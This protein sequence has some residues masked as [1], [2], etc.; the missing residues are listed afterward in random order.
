MAARVKAHV[1]PALITWARETAG[2]STPAE[3]AARLKIE[4]AQLA[5]WEDPTKEQKPSIPQ[6]RKLAA[7]FRRPLAVFYMAEPPRTFAVMRDLRRLPGTGP[8]HYSPALQL[9]I[10]TANERRELALELATDLERGIQRFTLAATQRE[11]PER[12]GDRIRAT[13]DVTA[14]LQA[15]WRDT[16]GRIVHPRQSFERKIKSRHPRAQP[17]HQSQFN[18]APCNTKN[19]PC[20]F[21]ATP[22]NAPCSLSR[23]EVFPRS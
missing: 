15:N 11:D 13:L 14:Q 2:F 21:P 7:L 17:C 3:A 23:G 16:D 1:N 19:A 8:R 12:V 6:L 4:E 18:A 20:S 5:A 22:K 9:E 10:R